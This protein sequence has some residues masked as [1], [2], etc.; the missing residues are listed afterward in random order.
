MYSFK[1]LP[2]Q[3]QNKKYL[4]FNKI[5]KIKGLLSFLVELNSVDGYKMAKSHTE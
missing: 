1:S 2:A 4:A 3:I 5:H